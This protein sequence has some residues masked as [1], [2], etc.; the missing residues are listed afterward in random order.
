[1]IILYKLLTL[2]DDRREKFIR[3]GLLE[4]GKHGYDETST[5]ELAKSAEVTKP[6]LF[7]YIESKK[8]FYTFLYE[9]SAKAV[10][11]KFKDFV[12][13]PGTDLLENLRLSYRWKLELMKIQP[14]E[15]SFLQI[16]IRKPPKTESMEELKEKHG[17]FEQQA[18]SIYSTEIDRTLFRPE[19]DVDKSLELIMWAIYGYG[20]KIIKKGQTSWQDFDFEEVGRE[21]DEYI[22]QLKKAFYK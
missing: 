12:H 3:A 22:D 4:F 1:V 6:L 11:S 18:L 2:D 19:L 5:N 9:Y 20:E 13:E 21:Y 16:H 10:M 14:S 17:E 15:Y 7:H 8:K